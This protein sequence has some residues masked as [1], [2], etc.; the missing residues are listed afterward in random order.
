MMTTNATPEPITGETRLY[1][2][3]GDPIRQVRSTQLLNRMASEKGA[4][5]VFVPFQFGNADI[6]TVLPALKTIKNLDGIIP[7]IPHKSNFLQFADSVTQ[8]AQMVGGTNILRRQG[9]GRWHGDILDG[10]GFVN[11]LLAANHAIKGRSILLL[12]AGGA[13]SAMAFALA[14]ASISRIRLYD[15]DSEK[16]DK[17]VANLQ[18]NF[19]GLDAEQGSPHPQGFDIIANATPLGMK[20]DDPFPLDPALLEPHQLV[21]EMIMKPPVTR[22]LKAA[23]KRR[24]ETH[25]GYATIRGQA[26]AMLDFFN[27]S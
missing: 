9:D 2:V 12:G 6:N 23:E 17:V 21:A 27:I 15:I 10:V 20:P 25:T 5:V 8:R 4:D 18:A 22:F 24:C 3:V 13:G 19:P 1:I 16:T 26:A 11:G 14:E 7:T